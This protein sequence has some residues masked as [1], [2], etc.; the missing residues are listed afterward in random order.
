[1][2]LA[3][4]KSGSGS[5]RFMAMVS[6]IQQGRAPLATASN[7]VA[8]A[9]KRLHPVDATVVKKSSFS[10]FNAAWVLLKVASVESAL[11]KAQRA[12]Q[13]ATQARHKVMAKQ[14]QEV[15]RH[16]ERLMGEQQKL[17]QNLMQEKQKSM[18]AQMKAQQDQQQMMGALNQMPPEMPSAQP[19]YGQMVAQQMAGQAQGGGPGGAAGAGGAGG[20]MM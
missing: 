10:L 8:E 6:A 2:A 18:Q 14:V 16:N 1:M 15:Q 7:S 3:R 20:G 12:V 19:P 5:N 13:G 9:A 11:A 4:E 17:Q